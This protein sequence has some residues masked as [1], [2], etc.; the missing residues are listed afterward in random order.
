MGKRKKPTATNAVVKEQR[1]FV[2]TGPRITRAALEEE[3]G[4]HPFFASMDLDVYF[5][6]FLR[7]IRPS[8]D[9]LESH[10]EFVLIV[11]NHPEIAWLEWDRQMGAVQRSLVEQYGPMVEGEQP[12]ARPDW[13]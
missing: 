12:P 8:K 6:G 5:G 7:N 1:F 13:H 9:P 10:I 4:K 2:E 11:W 3:L